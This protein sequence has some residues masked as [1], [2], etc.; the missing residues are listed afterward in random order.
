MYDVMAARLQCFGLSQ[1]IHHMKWRNGLCSL[2]DRRDHESP[3]KIKRLL[4]L[5]V[6]QDNLNCTQHSVFA[7]WALI[8]RFL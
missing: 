2:A 1:N 5:D 3:L 7:G 6:S 4:L 8:L